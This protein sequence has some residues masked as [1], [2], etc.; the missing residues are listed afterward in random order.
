MTD[1]LP[2][3][4]PETLPAAPQW[5]TDLQPMRDPSGMPAAM[6]PMQA[7]LHKAMDQRLDPES[8]QRFIQMARDQE[9]REREQS[10]AVAMNAVQSEVRPVFKTGYNAEKRTYHATLEGVHLALQ[11]AYTRQGFSLSFSERECSIEG[12]KRVHCTVMHSSG[13]STEHWIEVPLDDKGAKGAKNKT[14]IQGWVSSFSYAR[15]VLE[16]QIFAVATTDKETADR[17]GEP[18]QESITDQ[19]AADLEALI[20][21][22]GAA[23]PG[24]LK[25]CSKRAGFDLEH[26]SDLPASAYDAAVKAL[27]AKRAGGAA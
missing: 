26:F 3:E 27:E 14:E 17:D 24:F 11:P 18:A 19:Q 10:Y 2:A 5:T 21:D 1:K 4:R 8:M 12:Y 9:D 7:L 6:T 16:S 15:R 23:R 13:H 20:D 22:V 25:W